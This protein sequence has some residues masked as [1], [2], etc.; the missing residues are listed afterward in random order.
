MGKQGQTPEQELQLPPELL[1]RLND[2]DVTDP[3]AAVFPRKFRNTCHC[4]CGYQSA[5][6]QELTEV[7]EQELAALT[8]GLKI[9]P[10]G[11]FMKAVKR[12][13]R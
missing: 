1:S 3:Q 13:R 10:K 7:G 6:L 12:R 2:E 5:W 4:F 11:R 9:G 8:M